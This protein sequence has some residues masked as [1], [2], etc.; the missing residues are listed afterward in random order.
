MAK[1]EMA[2]ETGSLEFL[3]A[4]GAVDFTS[5][6]LTVAVT[7]AFHAPFECRGGELETKVAIVAHHCLRLDWVY[8][9][10]NMGEQVSDLLARAL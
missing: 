4:H 7:G 3:V 2:S 6:S 8:L 1:V 5:L 9:H 10:T